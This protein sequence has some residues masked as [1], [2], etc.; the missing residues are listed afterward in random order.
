[1]GQRKINAKG[2]IIHNEDIAAINI[3]ASD[4]TSSLPSRNYRRWKENMQTHA[5]DYRTQL[6]CAQRSKKL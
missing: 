5:R 3:D 6:N 1:M 4:S 2:Y